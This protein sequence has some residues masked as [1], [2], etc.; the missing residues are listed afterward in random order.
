MSNT[1]LPLTLYTAEQV[2]ELDRITIEEQGIPGLT[3]MTRAAAAA[4][5]VLKCGWPDVKRLMVCCGL[6]NN[7]GDGYLLASMASQNGYDV[8]VLVAGDENTLKGDARSAYEHWQR[9]SGQT[10]NYEQAAMALERIDLVVDAL[11]GTGLAREVQGSLATLIGNLNQSGK[12]VLAIDIP[13]GLNADTGQVM[14]IAIKASKTISYI[15]LKQGLFTASGRDY[16]GEVLFDGL[17]VPDEVMERIK[18]A[19]RVIDP[20]CMNDLLPQRQASTHKGQCG[21]VLL[22]GGDKGMTGA[23]QMSAEAAARSGAG[24]VSIA[25]RKEHA[26][27][28]T[29]LRPEL[30]CYGVESIVELE[31]LLINADV[32]AIGPGLGQSEWAESLLDRVLQSDLPLVVDADALNLL[33]KK[34]PGRNNWVLTPHPGEAARLLNGSNAAVQHDR[35]F[36]VKAIAEKFNAVTVLKGSGSLVFAPETQDC[37]LCR[38]GN[39]GMASGGM[40]DILTGVI[41]GLLA[42]N[43]PLIQATCCAVQIHARAADEAA[44]AGQRGT[45]ATDLLPYIRQLVNH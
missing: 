29:T 25:T 40:G 44:Q 27:Q 23:I 33:S 22:I 4:F 28:I 35:F 43:L 19:C 26:V 1:S 45:L 8:T 39:P 31:K 11:L 6:G 9:S 21:H 12:P 24:L 18:P 20:A 13:S 16:C 5:E 15:G 37:F 32:I 38:D 36:S 41:A 14:G 3:L 2:R 30:M 34:S 17:G 7:G 10:I 42:Q